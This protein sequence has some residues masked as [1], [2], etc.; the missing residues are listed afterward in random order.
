VRSFCVTTA[1]VLGA[2][3]VALVG[4]GGSAA[5]ASGTV[6]VSRDNAFIS[7]LS[8]LDISI[9][10]AVVGTVANGGCVKLTVPAGTRVIGSPNFWGNTR[11][12]ATIKVSSGGTVYVTAVP[13][14]EWPGPVHWAAMVVSA[15]GRRC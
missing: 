15:K 11:E 10:G 5:A 1:T 13:K 7:S 6:Y 8:N 3:V 2:A 12:S 4:K 9:D 14:M